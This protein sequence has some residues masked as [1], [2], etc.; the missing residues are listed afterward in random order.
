MCFRPLLVLFD[1]A[2]TMAYPWV[3]AE[4]FKVVFILFLKGKLIPMRAAGGG[5][6]CVAT[7]SISRAFV[8]HFRS[9]AGACYY[10]LLYVALYEYEGT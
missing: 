3:D 10:P 7:V 4:P 2:K 5:W 6:C 9:P 1:L 8:R